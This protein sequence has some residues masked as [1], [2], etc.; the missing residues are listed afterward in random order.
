MCLKR[1][2]DKLTKRLLF[3]VTDNLVTVGT[4][5]ASAR[6]VDPIVLTIA[7]FQNQLVEIGVSLNEIKRKH[8][9]NHVY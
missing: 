8:L 2:F 9:I 1:W 6:D 3:E 7:G 5:V 4:S